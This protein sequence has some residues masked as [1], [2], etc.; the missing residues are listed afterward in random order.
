MGISRIPD[1]VGDCVL[2]VVFSV[3]VKNARQIGI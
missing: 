3:N 2:Q 1:R